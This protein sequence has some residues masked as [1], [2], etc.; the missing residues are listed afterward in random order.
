MDR[1]WLDLRHAA[2]ALKGT[3]AFSVLAIATLALGIGANGAIFS[4]VQAVMLRPLPFPNPDHIV[5]PISTHSPSGS[6]PS[7]K[8]CS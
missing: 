1:L 8:S 4:I 7:V 5:V 3:P 6:C 2:R